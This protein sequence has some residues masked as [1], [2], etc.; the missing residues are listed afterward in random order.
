MS[1]PDR[2]D[3][4]GKAYDARLMRR[5]A[6]FVRPHASLVLASLAALLAVGAVQLVPPYLVKVVIDRFI[7]KREVAGLAVPVALFL[8]ALLAEFGLSF[9]QIYLLEATGQA[10]VFDLRSAVFAHLQRLPASFFDRMPV[11]RLMTRVTTDVEAINEAFTSGVVLMLSDLVKLLGIVVILVAMDVRLSLVTLAIVPPMLVVS[12]WFRVRVR[13]AYRTIR[14]AVARL[15]AYLQE[16]VTGM[17]ILQLTRH[18]RSAAAEFAALDGEHRRAQ[19][20]GVFYES[21]YSAVAELMG[22]VTL[23]AIIWAGGGRFLSGAV[24]FGTLVAFLEYANRFFR[25]IQEL[26]QRYTVMQAATAE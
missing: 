10:V 2:D 19:L 14:S 22:S 18:E 24:T 21:A 20:G 25:P 1:A 16:A 17:R 4:L 3:V 11:G 5:L 8:G 26:S 9:L 13:D 6:A 23:A 7:V 12:W 15:N